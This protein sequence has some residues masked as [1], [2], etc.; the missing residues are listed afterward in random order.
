VLELESAVVLHHQLQVVFQAAHLREVELEELFLL[1]QLLLQPA[2]VLLPLG[3]QP[4]GFLVVALGLLRVP[5]SV[6][7]VPV[8]LGDGERAALEGDLILEGVHGEVDLLVLLLG[9]AGIA[10]PQAA[11]KHLE[12]V[13]QG[14]YLFEVGLPLALGELVDLIEQ[15]SEVVDALGHAR[16]DDLHVH[17]DRLKNSCYNC[18]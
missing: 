8:L 12:F 6:V 4:H 1:E 5:G 18:E 15:Q 16:G 3:G 11:L 2:D 10:L 13:L 17:C 9:V 7:G 14:V